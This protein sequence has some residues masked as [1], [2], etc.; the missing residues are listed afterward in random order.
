LPKIVVLGSCRFEPYQF[1]AVPNK[2]PGAWNTEEGYQI[3]IAK[4]YPA[5][6]ETDEVWVYAPDGVSE[7]TG[8]DLAYARSRGKLIRYVAAPRRSSERWDV[9]DI[10]RDAFKRR[11]PADPEDGLLFVGFNEGYQLGFMWP[12][13]KAGLCPDCGQPLLGNAE[14]WRC[15]SCKVAWWRGKL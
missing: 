14:G 12:Y 15:P 3:A 1:L 6:D 7:H 10:V 13:P 2:I 8:R 4:F 9:E 5:I 11:F